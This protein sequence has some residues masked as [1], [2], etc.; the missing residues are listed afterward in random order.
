MTGGAEPK[1][2]KD[3]KVGKRAEPSA[4]S[5][6]AVELHHIPW[7]AKAALIA[8]LHAGD[9]PVMSVREAVSVYS[10]FQPAGRRVL[11]LLS[12]ELVFGKHLLTWI[13]LEQ[14]L[15]CIA[16]EYPYDPGEPL[17]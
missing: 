3:S 11:N 9:A 17:G 12:E 7:E 5:S 1:T 10:S 6:Q 2:T 8:D 14:L 13:E 16:H 4:N 15:V